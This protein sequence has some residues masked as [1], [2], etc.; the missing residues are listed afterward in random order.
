MSAQSLHH[1]C[2][3]VALWTVSRWDPLSTGLSRQEHWSGWLCPP[4]GDLPDPGPEPKAPAA[5]AS[6]V[7][8]VLLSHQGNP[9]KY[10]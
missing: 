7:D 4:P 6:Q 10:F 1:V 8:Y 9:E 2:L 5:P 3:F